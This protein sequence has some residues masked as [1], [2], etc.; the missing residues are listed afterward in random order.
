MPPPCYIIL[1]KRPR[2]AT[3]RRGGERKGKGWVRG[4]GGGT[5]TPSTGLRRGEGG[6]GSCRIHTS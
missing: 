4:V 1:C 5:G 3:G 6:V 2:D